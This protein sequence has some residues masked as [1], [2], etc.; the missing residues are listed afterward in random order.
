MPAQ[1]QPQHVEIP[2]HEDDRLLLPDGALRLVQV[3][4]LATLVEDRVLRR[5]EVL[6]LSRTQQPA[7]EPGHASPEIVN[8]EQQPRAEP[9]DH[10][11]V[12]PHRGEPRVDQHGLL[13]A[14][15]GHRREEGLA[16]RREA[17]PVH[18]RGVDRDVA[19]LE[20]FPSG[21]G[22]RRLEQLPGE[23][24]LGYGHRA[25]Q[26]L[27][28]VRP[29]A[30]GALGDDDPDASRDLAHRGRIV[31][32]EPLHEPREDVPALV[33]HEAVVA[34]FLGDDGEVAVGAAVER[35]GA[36]IVG[37]GALEL[38]GFAD[39]ADQV[40]AVAHLLDDLVGNHAHAENS[41]MV[42][43]VPPWFRGAKP[44]RATRRSP[45]TTRRTRSR[46]TPVPIP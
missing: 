36:A 34:A 45:E 33:A 44:K 41:T 27:E 10:A 22:V 14:E 6:G 28:R 43:P 16:R 23:P 9:G 19:A 46:T 17:E 35:T 3:V 24:V 7:A 25:E 12:I 2:F 42:T 15:L 37:A 30:R 21:L 1:H 18:R 11:A 5:V 38:D 40:G 31:H 29:R 20:I 39:D 13:D 8:R 4:E 32:A 26:W